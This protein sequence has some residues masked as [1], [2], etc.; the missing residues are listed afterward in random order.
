MTYLYASYVTKRIYMISWGASCRSISHMWHDSF[1]RDMT[2]CYVTWLIPMWHD[3]FMC[4]TWLIQVCD[5]TH[6][7]VW[8]DSFT[9]D[10]T[11]AYIT[12]LIH[13]WHDSLTFY[14]TPA[15]AT[16]FIHMWHDS[17]IRV[18]THSY[19]TWTIIRNL[20]GA[21]QCWLIWIVPL[22]H[23]SLIRDMTDSYVAWWHGTFIYEMTHHSDIKSS[24]LQFDMAYMTWFIHMWHIPKCHDPSLKLQAKLVAVRQTCRSHVHKWI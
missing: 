15:F 6:L 14:M 12:W 10:M 1:I 13:T 5:M 4:V 16:W 2:N 23:D 9:C 17:F 7:Y 18:M 20:S 11:Q 22:W 21:N 8:H 19:V 3:S 24:Q